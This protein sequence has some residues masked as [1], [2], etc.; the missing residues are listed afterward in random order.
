MEKYL[1]PD[2]FETDPN[3]L[4]AAKEYRHWYETFKNFLENN[5]SKEKPIEDK[6]KLSLLV[7]FISHS[8]YEYII[9]AK[10]FDDAIKILDSLYIKPTN[11]VFA[12]HLLSSRK[13]QTGET[14]DQYVQALRLLSQNCNFKPVSAEQN[15]NDF[16]RDAF[17]NGLLQS[18][19]RQRLLES[20]RLT[21]EEAVSQSRALEE[22]QKQSNT[23]T[24]SQN[25][26]NA[27]FSTEPATPTSEQSTST[28]ALQIQTCYF[29][30]N[31]R[32]PRNFCP[33]R[34]K[35][36]TYCQKVG[37][38]SK[39]CLRA[40]TNKSKSTSASTHVIATASSRFPY[41]LSKAVIKVLI[42]DTSANAL[43]DTGSSDSFLDLNF[44]KEHKFNIFACQGQ[45]SMASTEFSTDFQGYCFINLK[46]LNETYQKFKIFVLSN[47]C[48]DIIVGQ[49]IMKHHD[50]VNITFGGPKPPLIICCVAEAK[51]DPPSLFAN[52]TEDCRPIATKSRRYSEDD[53]IFIQEEVK[54]LL[55]EEV[56]EESISPWRAQVLITQNENHKRRMVIDYSQTINRFTL[57]D[58]YPL[59]N[60]E[61]LISKI[62]KYEIFSTID[63][64]SAYH[65]IPIKE[66]DKPLTAFEAGG[67]LYQFR[68]I[69]FGVTNGVSCFQRVIDSIIIKE[70]LQGVFAYLDDVTVCG[71]D[72]VSHDSNLN[73]F[74]AAARKYGL[75]LNQ[76]KCQYKKKCI[77]LLGYTIEN[78]TL[79]P[80]ADR[81]KPL[82]NLPVPVDLP[83]LR[84]VMGMFS[85][86]SKRI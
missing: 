82:L 24:L 61:A 49:D 86:Y 39:V 50:R 8:V 73:K 85:H 56:I 59:P 25:L 75:T 5:S 74:L 72:Q 62:S 14:I 13:Q 71:G 1:R 22:S 52:L 80:D 23:Y 68:R 4:N 46:M 60:I 36:C 33:A 67:R 17:I 29:C 6:H 30:G 44:A 37:H 53:I 2:R 20:N 32:H 3:T 15:R 27:T 70:H 12:R 31:S 16:I 81:L 55:D 26:I 21:L 40:K 64:K 57:L 7:N 76:N 42:N 18:T 79:K 47:L 58:A 45:V 19:I 54:K 10:T 28:A 63:L 65:Q 48:T 69:P 83:S 78:K 77:N 43:I 35:T 38:F 34:N 84:R 9:E 66:G 11:E 41:C 51:V